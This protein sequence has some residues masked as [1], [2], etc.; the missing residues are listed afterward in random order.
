[1][2]GI[3]KNCGISEEVWAICVDAERR[4]W[5]EFDA[6]AE[7]VNGDGTTIEHALL[8]CNMLARECTTA[9]EGVFH[10]WMGVLHRIITAYACH[11]MA[12]PEAEHAGLGERIRTAM[13]VECGE[14]SR[15]TD[16]EAT[17]MYMSSNLILNR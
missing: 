15:Y 8:F 12:V 9:P 6:V 3:L 2:E 14:A 11:T 16:Q 1:M 4:R 10:R 13:E 5:N 17:Q 7:L